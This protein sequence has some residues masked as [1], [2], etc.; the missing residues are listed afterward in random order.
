M[1]FYGWKFALLLFPVLIAMA[2]AGPAASDSFEGDLVLIPP[3]CEQQGKCKLKNEFSYVD[4]AGIGWTA[5]A[6]LVTDGASIPSWAQPIIGLPFT[7]AYV[8]AAVIHDHYCDRHVRPWRQTHRVFY[9]ALRKSGVPAET[10]GVMYFAVLVGGPKWV[11]LVKG[12]PCSAGLSCI[13][14]VDVAALVPDAN[15]TIN[16]DTILHIKRPDQYGSTRFEGLMAEN[17]PKLTPL[18]DALTPDQVE[19]LAESAMLDDFFFRNGDEVGSSISI[20]MSVE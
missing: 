2:S 7:P 12:V 13:N 9:D 20:Q 18:G 6:D 10:A 16:E 5:R 19:A 1:T 3:G 11:K 15:L 14:Q 8:K 4:P 17:L